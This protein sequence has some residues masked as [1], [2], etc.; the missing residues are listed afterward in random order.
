MT[1]MARSTDIRKI[2]ATIRWQA[3][4]KRIDGDN[5]RRWFGLVGIV[6]KSKMGAVIFELGLELRPD[7]TKNA[8]VAFG[9][10]CWAQLAA[11]W[12]PDSVDVTADMLTALADDVEQPLET[13]IS[14]DTAEEDHRRL[15]SF[16]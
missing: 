16:Y 4:R 9:L 15:L 13:L 11:L 5:P 12:C 3:V 7:E 10:A 2:K 1:D 6:G 14:L 8:T